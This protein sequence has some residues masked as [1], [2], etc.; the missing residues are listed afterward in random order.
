MSKMASRFRL[1]YTIKTKQPENPEGFV[2]CR[3]GD[4]PIWVSRYP[5]HYFD[6]ATKDVVP[7]G[8]GYPWLDKNNRLVAGPPYDTREEVENPENHRDIRDAIGLVDKKL[9]IVS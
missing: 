8:A 7:L 3:D 2:A 9:T 5:T 4:T 6:R 1:W